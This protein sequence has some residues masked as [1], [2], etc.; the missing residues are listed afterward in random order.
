MH[1]AAAEYDRLVDEAEEKSRLRG[2]LET[3]SQRV[4]TLEQEVERLR[5]Q[6]PRA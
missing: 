1:E 3:L 4:R 6:L 2:E 5:T